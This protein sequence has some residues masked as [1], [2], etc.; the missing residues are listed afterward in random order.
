MTKPL[1][2]TLA[3]AVLIATPIAGFAADPEGAR[4][5]APQTS[6]PKAEGKVRY[7]IT[8]A[9]SGSRL[10]KKICRTREEWLAVGVDP[11]QK[12]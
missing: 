6:E 3:S 12:S 9:L 8:E 7:C 2:L 11:T 1:L 10:L 4:P 5:P